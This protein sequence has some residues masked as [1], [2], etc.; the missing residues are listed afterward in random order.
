MRQTRRSAISH[1][2]TTLAAAS[3]STRLTAADDAAGLKGRVNHS[4][5][6]WCYSKVPLEDLCKA[7]KEMG[8]QSIELLGPDDWP[9]LQKYGLTCAMTTFPSIDGLGGITKSFNRVEHHDKLIQTY[10]D[11]IPKAA[12]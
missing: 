6:R 4:V 7:G 8:L 5:C 10:S 9:T 2:A 12:N 3:L 11:L 1:A